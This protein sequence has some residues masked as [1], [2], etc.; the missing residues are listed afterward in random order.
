MLATWY[1]QNPLGTVERA[2]TLEELL[3]SQT[4]RSVSPSDAPSGLIV[5]LSPAL[6]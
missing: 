5:T 4:T 6:T 3:P 2:I 1:D